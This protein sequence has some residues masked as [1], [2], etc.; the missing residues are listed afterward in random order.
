MTNKGGIL[1]DK[2]NVATKTEK[3]AL[4]NH[5]EKQIGD[6]VYTVTS[7]FSD[8]REFTSLVE[9]YITTKIFE[10]KEA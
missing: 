6:T 2:S 3:Q 4:P 1:I 8:T 9:S 5:L 10:E 7:I